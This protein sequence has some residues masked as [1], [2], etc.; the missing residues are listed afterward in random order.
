MDF[1]Y[2][3]TSE[4]Q[5]FRTEFRSWLEDH[6]PKDM[7]RGQDYKHTD[8]A[9]W[10]RLKAFREELGAKGWL[11]PTY[12][13]EYGG[14]GLTGALA[15]VIA[16]EMREV[17]G[18]GDQGG[19]LIYDNPFDLAPLV[20]WGTD[21]QKREILP[22]R[23]SGELLGW[24]LFTEPDAGSDLAG[25]QTRAVRDGDDWVITGEK[26]FV[27]GDSGYANPETK[28]P[29]EETLANSHMFCLAITD[30]DAPRHHNIGAFLIPGTTPG[31]TIQTLDL[32][33][34]HG[35]RQVYL[36]N[37]RVP[38]SLLLGGETQG[39]Q[40]SQ[41]ALEIEHGGGG[42]PPPKDKAVEAL[43]TWVRQNGKG[44]DPHVRQ[45]VAQAVIEKDI[46]RLI[47][48][49][50]HWMVES[51]REMTFHGSQQAL[52]RKSSGIR[53]S[54]IIR[55]VMGP[56][57]ML[58]IEDPSAPFKGEMELHQRE[59]LAAAHPGGTVEVQKV[60]MA[61]RMGVSRTRERAAPT[62]AT[63]SSS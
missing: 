57:A 22:R 54:D 18:G 41:T 11:Y 15:V 26:V 5:Q 23:L 33:V 13:A 4:Q 52:W 53:I 20:V 16:E 60:I 27:G 62:P 19:G 28:L 1:E 44:S 48:T 46:M 58:D 39:W 24:Q 63:V 45:A 47:A 37:V 43:V 2:H 40:V 31:I 30:P 17:T 9:T 36:E 49:R 32:L 8:A 10:R 35:K 25:L 12:P 3:Y 51:K 59:S 7:E 21:E 55:D 56:Y 61:R 14:G 6:F 38:G 50:N 29:D 34:G 42:G